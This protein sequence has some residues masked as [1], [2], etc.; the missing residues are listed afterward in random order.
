M[1][2]QEEEQQP[3][4]PPRGVIRRLIDVIHPQ[5]QEIA[6][7]VEQARLAAELVAHNLQA[8]RD[9]DELH[10]LRAQQVARRNE[11]M[12]LATHS[13]REAMM[14]KKLDASWRAYAASTVRDYLDRHEIRNPRDRVQIME[15]AIAAYI[16]T[17]AQ[18]PAITVAQINTM[19]Q[20]N[21]N[22][23]GIVDN[24]VWYNPFTWHLTSTLSGNAN[25][26]SRELNSY[27]AS[28]VACLALGAATITAAGI[29]I[30]SKVCSHLT[31]FFTIP[32]AAQ[33]LTLPSVT[34]TLPKSLENMI[35][36][37]SQNAIDIS[38]ALSAIQ[39]HGRDNSTS[40]EL[41][42]ELAGRGISALC[43]GC[44]TGINAVIELSR[45]QR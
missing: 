26:S 37:S 31:N 34:V 14:G 20:H 12:D 15:G 24:R 1:A 36:T 17:I 10:R 33:P 9:E 23:A 35:A 39:S 11:H 45:S 38:S 29:Y 8:A 19:L 5:N 4:Q 16:D 27:T 28:Q 40:I 41:T 2:E 30:T 42:M 3:Q 32:K 43:R 44:K 21:D 7:E 6:L 25:G 18:E 13:I 22:V